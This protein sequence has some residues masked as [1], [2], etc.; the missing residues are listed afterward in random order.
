MN[1]VLMEYVRDQHLFDDETSHRNIVRNPVLELLSQSSIRLPSEFE[2]HSV[3][4]FEGIAV[5]AFL[6]A[7]ATGRIASSGLSDV[8]VRRTLREHG[9]YVSFAYPHLLRFY[10][11]LS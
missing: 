7:A 5:P 6:A 3:A 1:M 9:R 10:E 2:N 4:E 8:V 11:A